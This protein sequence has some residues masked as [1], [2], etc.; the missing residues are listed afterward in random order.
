MNLPGLAEPA[1]R[2]TLGLAVPL[3][4][5]VKKDIDSIVL[6]HDTTATAGT[7]PVHKIPRFAVL[8]D[9]TTTT[10]QKRAELELA[11]LRLRHDLHYLGVRHKL[12][13]LRVRHKLHR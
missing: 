5:T 10:T 13:G 7:K 9:D 8:M 3:L 6:V 2:A 12:E 1:I 4:F 11:G